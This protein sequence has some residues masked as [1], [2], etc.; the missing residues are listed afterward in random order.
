MPP[1]LRAIYVRLVEVRDKAVMHQEIRIL[2]VVNGK[3]YFEMSNDGMTSSHVQILPASDF[4]S[5]MAANGWRF[6][7][8]HSFKRPEG[9]APFL[10]VTYK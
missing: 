8:K 10:E 5:I 3:V 9:L 2:D 6:R 4:P 1:H 7:M